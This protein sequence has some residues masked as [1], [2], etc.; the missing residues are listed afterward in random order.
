MRRDY[1]QQSRNRRPMAVPTYRI[2]RP[3]SAIERAGWIFLIST[4][5]LALAIMTFAAWRVAF[6]I[7]GVHGQN[8]SKEEWEAV[9]P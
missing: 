5:G 4:I 3:V 8:V 7:D 6:G 1:A 9:L 2:V